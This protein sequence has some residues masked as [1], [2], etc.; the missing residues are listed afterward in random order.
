LSAGYKNSKGVTY[1][2]QGFCFWLIG[3][4]AGIGVRR[5]RLRLNFG[6]LTKKQQES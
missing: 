2:K 5:G 1:E 4:G 6:T 3:D